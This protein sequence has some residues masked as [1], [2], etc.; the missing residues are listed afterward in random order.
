M[1]AWDLGVRHGPLA[2]SRQLIAA[3]TFKHMCVYTVVSAIHLAISV[4]VSLTVRR[5]EYRFDPGRKL[6]NRLP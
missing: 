2:R 4:P 5:L 6:Q 1:G 3:D